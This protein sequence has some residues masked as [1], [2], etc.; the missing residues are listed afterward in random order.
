VIS[1]N[2]TFLLWIPKD[3]TFENLLFVGSH[4]PD[5]DDVVFQHF[6]SASVVD[7][8]TNDLSRQFGDK[9]IYFEQ[10][11]SLALPLARTGLEEKK[12]QFRR[13]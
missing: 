13:H 5:H 2:G 11:D 10:A 8:V 7:S 4:M 3:L 1:D 6:K 9:I 12:K